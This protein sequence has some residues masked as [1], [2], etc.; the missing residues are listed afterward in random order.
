M[1][2]SPTG[3]FHIGSA[4]T[5]LFNYLFARRYGGRFILRI[6]DTDKERSEEKYLDNILESLA[7]LG[8]EY[9]E[10]PS[11]PGLAGP[12]FQM[13]RLDIYESFCKRLL[14]EGK[15]YYCYMSPE[16]L[17]QARQED[18]KAG[19][20]PKYRGQ[21]RDLSKK[22]RSSFEKAGRKPVVRFKVEPQKIVYD[23]LVRGEIE[24]DSEVFGDWVIV[25]SDGLP[26]YNFANVLDDHLMEISHVLRGEE[27]ISNTPRQ[28]MM[29]E[30]LGWES[31]KYGHLPIILNEDR[32]K[33][34]KRSG[35]TSIFS[36]KELGYLPEAIIN[37]L[38][39]MGWSPGDNQEIFSLSDL[40][41]NFDI[42]QVQSSPA[43]FNIEKLQ[44]FNGVYIRNQDKEVMEQLLFERIEKAF[45]GASQRVSSFE[46]FQSVYP[47][48]IE[49]LQYL[50]QVAE[51]TRFFYVKKIE[52]DPMDLVDKKRSR[53]EARAILEASLNVLKELED[54]DWQASNIENLLRSLMKEK[55]WRARDIFMALRIAL[56][57]TKTSPPLFDSMSVIGKEWVLERIEDA[58]LLLE[59]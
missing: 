52:V 51:F 15:A 23:D 22:E 36:Y 6:E 57:G 26:T 43:V 5:T 31:P 8:I 46:Y 56:T 49:R 12:Y 24:I 2:P 14:E 28:L 27:H 30:A 47:L 59:E 21:H 35:P 20:P 44:W 37:F 54:Q 18:K 25:R 7:W 34:S 41:R 48:V 4:R 11:K 45:L 38:V 53:S 29:Y 58:I 55:S 3:L 42:D 32:S 50:Q 33:M 19:R 10:G 39:L 13:Q 17:D 40:E 9:D 1:A 16:E